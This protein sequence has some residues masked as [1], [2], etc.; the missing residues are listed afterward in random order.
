MQLLRLAGSHA[1]DNVS[2]WMEPPRY[3]ELSASV[4][5]H[6]GPHIVQT[7]ELCA[8]DLVAVV[9]SCSSTTAYMEEHMGHSV[10]RQVSNTLSVCNAEVLRRCLSRTWCTS[11]SPSRHPLRQVAG[12]ANASAAMKVY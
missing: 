2:V 3:M 10:F 12:P 6:A 7:F 1:H 4:S 11:A 8:A 9:Q 5:G